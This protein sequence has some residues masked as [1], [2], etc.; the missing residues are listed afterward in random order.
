MH[1]A[2]LYLPLRSPELRCA[3]ARCNASSGLD[4]KKGMPKHPFS[5][6]VPFSLAA[7]HGCPARCLEQAAPIPRQQAEAL[8]ECRRYR[9]VLACIV[10]RPLL[11]NQSGR[12]LLHCGQLL[13]RHRLYRLLGLSVCCLLSAGLLRLRVHDRLA[14]DDLRTRQRLLRCRLGFGFSCLLG[15]ALGFALTA[16][17]L[18]RIVRCAAA[19]RQRRGGS[20]C[21]F[22]L[23]DNRLRGGLGRCFRLGDLRYLLRRFLGRLYRNIGRPRLVQVLR[24]LCA[25]RCLRSQQAGRL[26]RVRRS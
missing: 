6:P 2:F 1:R 13:G 25:R 7:S 21:R 12:L 15:Q 8:V 16:T 4:E 26:A 17:N 20:Q 24:W 11:G 18:A 3:R 22:G 23:L 9:L 14:G 19:R 5:T 10:G